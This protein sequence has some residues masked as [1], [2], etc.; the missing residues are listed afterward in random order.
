MENKNTIIAIT[1]MVLVWFTFSFLFPAKDSVDTAEVQDVASNITSAEDENKDN[2]TQPE[3]DFFSI[4]NEQVS[5]SEVIF[6]SSIYDIVFSENEASIKKICFP[7]YLD[8]TTNS[9]TVCMINSLSGGKYFQSEFRQNL[10]SGKYYLYSISDTNVIFRKDLNG[11]EIYKNFYFEKD[12]YIIKLSTEVKNRTIST[13]QDSY[14]IGF[15]NSI[16]DNQSKNR[17]DFEGSI[18]LHDDEIVKEDHDDLVNGHTSYGEKTLWSGFTLKYFMSLFINELNDAQVVVS[19]NDKYFLHQIN[20]PE[21][22]IL[23]GET[24]TFT[25]LLYSGPKETNQLSKF[26]Y[27]LSRAVDFGFFSFLAKPLHFFL[28]Y[29]YNILGN[30]GI[31]IILLTVIIKLIFWPLTQKS[32]VSMKAMQKLQPEMKKIREKYR[33]DRDGLNRATMQ[34][35]Q[36]NRVNP[37]GGCLPMLVQIPVFF[38]LYKVLLDTIELRHAPFMLWI[39]DLSVKDPYFVTPVLMGITMFIQQKLTPSTMDPIQAKMML[40][41]P[42]VFTFLFLNFPAGLVLYWLVNNLLTILQQYLIYRRAD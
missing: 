4:V 9:Q 32:Y 18:T 10:N 12:S 27:N 42:I 34:L 14:S 19:C 20:Y 38:A 28:N 25:T 17:F 37:L 41:M 11:I 23:P 30:Y 5:D 13:L 21:F 2:F 8:S 7:K 3:K 36:E 40:A 33:T 39:T 16:I 22:S 24:L 6:S 26:D 29:F 35:Y 15:Y 31:S 1:L